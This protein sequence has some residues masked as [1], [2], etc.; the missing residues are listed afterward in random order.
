[1]KIQFLYLK[2]KYTSISTLI[3]LLALFLLEKYGDLTL[4]KILMV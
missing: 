2:D 1:M 3:Q 4:Q